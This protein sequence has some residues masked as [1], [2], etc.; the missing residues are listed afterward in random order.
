MIEKSSV[1]VLGA[2]SWGTALAQHLDRVGH[3]VT[4]WGRDKEVLDSIA[5]SHR[6]P[7]YFPDLPLSEKIRAEP[8]LAK[9]VAGKSLIVFAV[10]SDAMHEVAKAAKSN[11][12]KGA[13][14]CSTAKGLEDGTLKPMSDVLTAEFGPD[15]K[16]CVLSGPSF[17]KEV[18]VGLPTAVT[19]AAKNLDIAAEGAAYFHIDHF[20]VYTTDDVIGVEFGGVVKNVIALAIGLVEGMGMGANARAALL[21]RG[22]LEMQRLTLALGGQPVTITGLSGLGD[23]FLTATGDL[24]R[25]RQVGLR[26]GRGEKLADILE[27]LGQVAESVKATPKVAAIAKRFNV[28][29]PIIEE[30]D[31][32]LTG[33][34]KVEDSVRRLLAR[35]P[36]TENSIR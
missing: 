27:S 13:V 17:A 1:A 15:A 31:K 20:R 25:N 16:V 4:I 12:Q 33:E 22:L 11:I 19:M 32:I 26:L 14:L 7:H 8:D 30:V 3:E 24:S 23:L 9:A 36:A 10:P 6:N 29:T 2:G 5:K 28:K 21:T 18:L 34:S 35:A